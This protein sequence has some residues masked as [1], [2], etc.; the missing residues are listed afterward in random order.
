MTLGREDL[1]TGKSVRITAE[2]S[3]RV[4]GYI[5]FAR[6][7]S[8]IIKVVIFVQGQRF[9]GYVSASDLKLLL[10]RKTGKVVIH[11]KVV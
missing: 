11:R 7:P 4:S 9:K 6:G 10:S 8:E 2:P 3:Q 1:L 5:A